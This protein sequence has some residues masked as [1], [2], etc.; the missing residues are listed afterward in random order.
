[1]NI[2]YQTYDPKR[3]E[4]VLLTINA[5]H[6]DASNVKE[7]KSQIDK[8]EFKHKQVLL[9]MS[10]LSFVDSSGLGAILSM[11]RN[12]IANDGSLNLFGLTTPVRALFELVKMHRVFTI[13]N[14]KDEALNV[15]RASG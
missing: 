3:P 2:S 1:M 14:T 7:F 8:L 13:F 11:R 6:L 15:L 9:D 5:E 10:P 4:V 12:I